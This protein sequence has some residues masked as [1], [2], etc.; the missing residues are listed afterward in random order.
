MYG[1]LYV[2]HD[3]DGY[4]ADPEKYVAAAKI[5]PR[6]LLLKDRRPRTEWTYADLAAP[7]EDMSH[8]GGRNFGNGK[9][10][11]SVANCIACHRLQGAGNTF[12]PDLTKI[13]PKWK[14]ADILNELLTPSAR[15]NEKFQTN[16]FE[17][18]SGKVVTGLIL[19]ETPETI[20]IIENPLASATPTLIRR[21]DVVDRQRS[22]TSMMPKGL[23]DKL[24]RDEI[25]DLVAYVAAGG[26]QNRRE[27][28][29]MQHDHHSH[30]SAK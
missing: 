15:I 16:V 14:P 27:F 30:A 2:V 19:E 20:K 18:G 23:L 29:P 21:G 6:D 1:A 26:Q 8:V 17:L 10:I 5:T 13:D 11:F 25:L 12:G 28:Q 9:Q 22:K 3:L 24:T 7:I 4:L